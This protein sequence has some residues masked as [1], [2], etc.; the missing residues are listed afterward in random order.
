MGQYKKY[1]NNVSANSWKILNE[2]TITYDNFTRGLAR[3]RNGSKKNHLE[4][5]KKS[6]VQNETKKFKYHRNIPS[7]C[8]RACFERENKILQNIA[9]TYYFYDEARKHSTCLRA[10]DGILIFITFV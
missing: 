4:T 6:H 8:H 7:K 2:S 5:H 1:A 10:I 9:Q 3:Q